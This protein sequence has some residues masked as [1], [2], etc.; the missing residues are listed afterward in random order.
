MTEMVKID[1][2][3]FL[4][5][6]SWQKPKPGDQSV[7]DIVRERTHRAQHR[8]KTLLVRAMEEGERRSRLPH[9][10]PHHV[11]GSLVDLQ[12]VRLARTLTGLE[13]DQPDE[14]QHLSLLLG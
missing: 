13:E 8:V 4:Y 9:V 3:V 2:C 6:R 5:I 1:T 10:V 11:R 7:S 12:P 14:R